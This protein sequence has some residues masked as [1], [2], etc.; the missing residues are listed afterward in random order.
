MIVRGTKAG[1]RS[2]IDS[3]DFD[4]IEMYFKFDNKS[5]YSDMTIFKLIA[6][7]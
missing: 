1:K 2:G 6:I 5:E 3:K 4:I 7:C